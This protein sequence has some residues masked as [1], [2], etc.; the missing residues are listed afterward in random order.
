VLP[1]DQV[2]NCTTPG[3]RKIVVCPATIRD[4]IS[5]SSCQLC[6]ISNREAIIGFPAHGTQAKKAARVFSIQSIH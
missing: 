4:G 5:C 2:E 6:A 3:G 1:I